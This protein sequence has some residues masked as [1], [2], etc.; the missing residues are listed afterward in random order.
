[1]LCTSAVVVFWLLSLLGRDVEAQVVRGVV[2][3]RVD[4]V[5]VDGARVTAE[6]RLGKTLGETI[7]D[8]Q[9]RYFLRFS[10]RPR[11]PLRLSITRI[12]M[13]PT[14]SDELTLSATD[15]VTAD[16]YVRELP[17]DLDEVRT[18]A[19]ASLNSSRLQNA[20][21]RGWRVFDP[22][23]IEARG[24]SAQGLNDLLRSLGAPGLLVPFRADDCV[25]TTRTG[26]CLALIIDNVPVSGNVHMNP[27]DIYFLAIV[28]SSDARIEWGD[29][30][31]YGAL[32]I[33]T[34]MNG[35][36]QRP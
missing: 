28:G 36:L 3:S 25:K 2:R 14:L 16:H 31:A 26:R 22:S 20:Y 21:R 34:R 8:D 18:E 24:A 33:Y 11:A 4:S 27:R 15:T 19:V 17:T 23:T 32:A 6:D 13:S 5:A 10:I 9:G 7:T 30:A 1:M 29:R 12:G 35:D